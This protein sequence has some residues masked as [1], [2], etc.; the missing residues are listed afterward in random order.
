MTAAMPAP[1]DVKLMNM[2]ASVLFVGCAMA[3]LAAGASTATSRSA[4]TL[5]KPLAD[6][7]CSTSAGVTV[8]VHA[9]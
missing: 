4:C 8:A 9:Q 5:V 2:T 7:H 6:S 1:L 3:V